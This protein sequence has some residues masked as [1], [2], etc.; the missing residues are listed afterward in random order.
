V[1]T[2]ADWSFLKLNRPTDLKVILPTGRINL[3]NDWKV[4]LQTG[5]FANRFGWKVIFP[6]G[7]TVMP[8][9]WKVIFC[10]LVGM[11]VCMPIGRFAAV[12]V[13]KL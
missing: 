12:T 1:D 11:R 9:G 4:T 10:Q 3:P 13:S 7:G 6:T 2:F 8:T 5:R